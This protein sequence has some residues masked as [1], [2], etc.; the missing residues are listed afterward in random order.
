MSDQDIERITVGKFQVSIVGLKEAVSALAESHGGMGDDEIGEAMLASLEK[1]NY[2]PASARDEYRK[3]FAR[4]FR[5]ALG[6][7]YV[8]EKPEGLD[9]KVL[10]SGCAQ[11]EGLT[12][13]VMETLIEMKVLAGLEHLKD[14][15]EIA[16]YGVLSVP[17]LVI[18][19]KVVFQGSVPPRE[20]IKG[21][22]REAL[23]G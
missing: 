19:E 16:R 17:A 14:I 12:R 18:N 6:H 13:L 8:Q 20:K 1:K 10:G 23:G 11:C 9:I 5:K 3:S 2:I 22:I 15:R 21:W 7:P 4:E